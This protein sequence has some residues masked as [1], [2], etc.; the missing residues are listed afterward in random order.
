MERKLVLLRLTVFWN[1]CNPLILLGA[2]LLTLVILK[3]L[4]QF[5][6]S[7]PMFQHFW[8]GRGKSGKK[9][10]GTDLCSS[11]SNIEKSKKGN[12]SKRN[13]GTN[14][15]FFIYIYIVNTNKSKVSKKAHNKIND[16]HLPQNSLPPQ[17]VP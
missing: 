6:D 3:M 1:G 14:H 8:R 12:R 4:I 9:K 7:V 10:V 17:S 11:R 5:C 13:T 2:I 15:L 16:L